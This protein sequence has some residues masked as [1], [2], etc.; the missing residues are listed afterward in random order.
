MAQGAIAMANRKGLTLIEVMIALTIL[1][2]AMLSM[3][4]YLT[5][6]ARTISAADV[7]ATA[8]ELAADKLEAVKA[9]PRYA[10]IDTL[11]GGTEHLSSP[12]QGYTRVTTVQRVG[13]GDEDLYDY[14][15]VTVTVSNSRLPNPVSKTSIIAAF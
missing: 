10:A 6:F 11:Y 15:T 7:V 3:A 5:K 13:G 14:R 9:S 12:Y 8:N 4:A 1:A 2:G